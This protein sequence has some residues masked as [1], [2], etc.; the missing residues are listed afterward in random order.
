MPLSCGKI[1]AN[2]T[3]EGSYV[4]FAY[5]GNGKCVAIP[6]Q[7]D[8]PIRSRAKLEPF[9]VIEQDGVV[10]LWAGDPD[11]MGKTRP[12]RMPEFVG[13]EINGCT[14]SRRP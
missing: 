13:R 1:L 14:R 7:T 3:L 9:P 11:R 10:W 8:A 2:G 6:S 4:G 12:P 5:D